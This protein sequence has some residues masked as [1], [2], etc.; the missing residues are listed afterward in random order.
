ML[1]T[2]L[3]AAVLLFVLA[4][5]FY[6]ACS[7]FHAIVASGT[8]SRQIDK[9]GDARTIGYGAM[10]VEGVVAVIAL[11]LVLMVETVRTLRR[12]L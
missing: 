11:A 2:I 10:L 4:W 9:E 6:G 7:G 8:S 5:R 1:F 3:L 12:T